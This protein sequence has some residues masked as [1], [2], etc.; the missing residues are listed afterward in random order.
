MKEK[1]LPLGTVCMLKG[2]KKALMIIGYCPQAVGNSENEEKMYDYVACL[3]PEGIISSDQNLVFNHDQI[4]HIVREV[5]VEPETD[6]FLKK[7]R[8][9]MFAVENGTLDINKISQE[10]QV[11]LNNDSSNDDSSNNAGNT[12]NVGNPSD[13]VNPNA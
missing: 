11:I 13:T 12:N 6:D 7:L 4:D 3:Y 9:V 8:V 5:N 1:Y 2:G 10:M